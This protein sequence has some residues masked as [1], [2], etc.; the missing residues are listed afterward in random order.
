MLVCQRDAAER[1]FS[2]DG[3][4]LFHIIPDADKRETDQ[5][6]VLEQNFSLRDLVLGGSAFLIE[7]LASPFS[8]TPAFPLDIHLQPVIA[9][10]LQTVVPSTRACC[11]ILLSPD[12]ILQ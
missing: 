4:A 11:C 1:H 5:H 6:I 8:N 10:A 7:L 2:I 9:T 12:S 3:S